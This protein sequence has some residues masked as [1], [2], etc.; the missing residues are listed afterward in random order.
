MLKIKWWQ[1]Q[2][3]QGWRFLCKLG[4]HDDYTTGQIGTLICARCKRIV[5][6]LINGTSKL[7]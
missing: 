1:K 3:S 6:L 7:S 4:F 5:G 2:K